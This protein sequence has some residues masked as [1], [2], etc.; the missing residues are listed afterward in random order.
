MENAKNRC[1]NGVSWSYDP[2][3][4]CVTISGNGEM[5]NWEGI[6]Q[7]PWH[8]HFGE[9]RKVVVEEGVASVGDLAFFSCEK[10]T[11]IVL[12]GTVELLGVQCFGS[13]A[14]LV[15]VTIPE[16]VKVI[17]A[18]A[19]RLCTSLARV[20]LPASLTNIDMRAFG[21]DSALACVYYG[22]TR[23]QWEQVA[24]SMS[25][26]D[27][28]YLMQADL[29]CLGAP[30][31]VTA[32]YE[33]VNRDDWFADAAQYLG[34]NGYLGEAAL[35]AA[36]RCFGPQLPAKE[37]FIL[38]ILYARAGAPGMY[39]SSLDWAADNGLVSG[40][41]SAAEGISMAELA[42]ILYRTARNNGEEA[43]K[44]AAPFQPAGLTEEEEALCWCRACGFLA[45]LPSER[46]G[47]GLTRKEAASVIAS[48]LKSG[49]SAANRRSE[50]VNELKAALKRGGNGKLYIA[51]PNLTEPGITA[52][53]GDCTLI[54][55]PDG[56][57]MM[58]DAG[59]TAC[60]KHVISLLEELELTH[61]DY[62]VLSHAHDDHA[63]G[64]MAVAQYIYGQEGGYIGAYRRSSYAAGAAEQA[65]L[66]CAKERGADIFTDVKAKDKWN[67]GGVTIDI[68][69]PDE[70]LLAEC[71]GNVEDLN[72]SSILMKFTYG[73]STFLTGGDLYKNRETWLASVY[74]GFL[75]ADVCKANH[76]GTHTSGGVQWLEM[77]SP[78]VMFAPADDA[79]DT[80]FV[81][82]AAR[83]GI[84][85][86]SVGMD[87]LVMIGMDDA[88]NYKVVS[89]YDSLLRKDYRGT[90]GKRTGN[91]WD[92]EVCDEL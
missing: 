92:Q 86:Y 26:S 49:A 20:H 90:V 9:L 57:T 4:A 21:K 66:A 7:V 14:S 25:A 88:G 85:Y 69:N 39:R 40:N 16:G 37:A 46:S 13:C 87:G 32:V 56:Q 10:L 29:H 11:E 15:S 70:A 73:A 35:P 24:I 52:K 5:E 33:D 63:G 75:K 27:N 59:Y 28:Q 34:E 60:S 54:L 12:A 64:L 44:H 47:K 31:D 72:N 17:G 84:A 82:R 77:V 91:A 8:D 55:F 80:P 45:G 1:G 36:G 2:D 6:K 23:L 50:I 42:V 62:V 22:G 74:G 3:T 43:C 78:A 79:G 83:M 65:F 48:Y 76:H 81:R 41:F 51:A 71:T 30:Y 58:I 68:L 19:F 53:S 18:K 38:N 61:L 67:I 89:Q